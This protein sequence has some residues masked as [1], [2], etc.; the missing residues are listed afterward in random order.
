MY[1][2]LIISGDLIEYA[3]YQK[4]TSS[5]VSPPRGIHVGRDTTERMFGKKRFDNLARARKNCVRR[6]FVASA[7]VRECVF[8]TLTFDEENATHSY[9]VAGE[10]FNSFCKRLYR[11]YKKRFTVVA[12]PER[13]E[14]GRVHIHAV[15]F[16]T[17]LEKE[18]DRENIERL[19]GYGFIKIKGRKLS[20]KLCFYLAKYITKQEGDFEPATKAFWVSHGLEKSLE[21]VDDHAEYLAKNLGGDMLS[22]SSRG[23]VYFGKI[24]RSKRIITW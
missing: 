16:G 18:S 20:P 5:V 12:V 14:S 4:N 6:M 11:S 1:K 15:L 13:H 10:A 17:D 7:E 22:E 24:T 9:R 23:S 21:F 2:K 19:W 8:V 3:T